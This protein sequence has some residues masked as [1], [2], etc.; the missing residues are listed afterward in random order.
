MATQWDDGWHNDATPPEPLYVE[1]KRNIVL[2][3]PASITQSSGHAH[4]DLLGL[5]SDPLHKWWDATTSQRIYDEMPDPTPTGPPTMWAPGSDNERFSAER[6]ALRSAPLGIELTTASAVCNFE[7]ERPEGL[8]RQGNVLQLEMEG[9][10]MLTSIHT[11]TWKRRSRVSR[12][13]L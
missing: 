12:P 11:Q 13:H 5:E 1:G 9:E 7:G 4:A 6:M 10:V 8:I 3:T 2:L